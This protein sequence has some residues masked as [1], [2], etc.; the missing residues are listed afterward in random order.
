LR[1]EQIKLQVA[2]ANALMHSKG[3]A[4]PEPR[5]AV[6]QARLFMERAG[7]L[8]EPPEDP[9]V[10]FSVLFGVWAANILAFNGDVCRDLAT[11]F[12]ALAETQGTTAARMIGHRML[13][14]TFHYS[15]DLVQARAQYDQALDLYDSAVHRPLATRFGHE[16]EVAVLSYRA[17]TLWML[18][19]PEAAVRDS[20]CAVKSARECGHTPTLLF[21]LGFTPQI[22]LERGDYAATKLR[23]DELAELAEEKDASF[24]RA[25]AMLMRARLMLHNGNAAEAGRLLPAGVAAWSST[26]AKVHMPNWLLLSARVHAELDQYDEAWRFLGEARRLIETTKEKWFQAEFDRVTGEIALMSP[27]R[28]ASKAAAY[29]ESALAGART[30]QAKS[31]ELRAATSL[32]RL[33]RG[34]GR[35]NEARDLLAPVYDWFTEGFDTRDLKEAKTLLGEL[36]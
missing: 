3:W 28:D 27:E 29:F 17:F 31:F 6:E 22:H 15:G 23:N 34:Q 30:Q 13:G 5:A 32:A 7:V 25:L 21:A 10:L 24:W 4:A 33:W 1:R 18:G 16:T 9:L 12:L 8:G 11:Q 2:L 19:Y 36:A 26:G 35:R 20:E 14:N